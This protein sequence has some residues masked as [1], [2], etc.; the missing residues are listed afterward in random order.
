MTE[1]AA[2]LYLVWLER[3]VLD[4]EIR[5]ADAFDAYFKLRRQWYEARMRKLAL[6]S[7][8]K[9]VQTGDSH[10]ER[11]AVQP[12]TTH[13]GESDVSVRDETASDEPAQ[14]I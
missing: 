12:E 8:G 3:K 2:V 13:S 11:P 5:N 9:L 6:D 4:V 10:S 14:P 7:K 1:T